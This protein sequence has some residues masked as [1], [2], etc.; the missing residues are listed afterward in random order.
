VCLV[1]LHGLAAADAIKARAEAWSSPIGCGLSPRGNWDDP[2][3]C[4]EL[5]LMGSESKRV[6]K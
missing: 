4:N 5:R 2:V 1:V 6:A 3:I